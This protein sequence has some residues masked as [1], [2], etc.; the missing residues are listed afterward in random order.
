[1]IFQ[2]ALE[3]YLT[4]LEINVDTTE[5]VQLLTIFNIFGP[6]IIPVGCFEC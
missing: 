1:M 2:L 4:P 3:F 6:T 5:I